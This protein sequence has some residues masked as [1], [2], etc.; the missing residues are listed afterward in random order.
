MKKPIISVG[1]EKVGDYQEIPKFSLDESTTIRTKTGNVMCEHTTIEDVKIMREILKI[2]KV[3]LDLENVCLMSISSMPCDPVIS[4][5]LTL[6]YKHNGIIS[7]QNVCVSS[8]VTIPEEQETAKE[9]INY[10]NKIA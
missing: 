7:H 10:I 8:F 1:F 2:R 9:I 6:Y 4:L 3:T 5:S